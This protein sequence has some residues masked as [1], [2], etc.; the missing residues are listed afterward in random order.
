[1]TDIEKEI[2]KEILLA[3]RHLSRAVAKMKVNKDTHAVKECNR[4]IKQLDN[5]EI[6]YRG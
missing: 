3:H 2:R 1:V 6:V 4:M 5:W